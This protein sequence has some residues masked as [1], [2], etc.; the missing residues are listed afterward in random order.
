MVGWV[1]LGMGMGMGDGG[2][3]GWGGVGGHWTLL[4]NVVPNAM[5]GLL[6]SHVHHAFCNI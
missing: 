3:V 4:D 2:G 1:G 5:P 6:V